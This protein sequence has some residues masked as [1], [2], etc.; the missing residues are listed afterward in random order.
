M[1]VSWLHVSSHT[2]DTALSAS[3]HD[4]A[5]PT[6]CFL[7]RVLPDWTFTLFGQKFSLNP[8]PFNH[9]EHMMISLMANVSFT[10]PYTF[11]IIPVQ[12]MPQYFNMPFARNRGYQLCISL[13]VNLFGVGMAGV[14]RRFLVYPSIAIW[15]QNLPYVALIK[16]FHS[17]TDEPVWGPGKRVYTW[18]REKIFLWGTAFM[19]VYFMLPGYM[20]SI[21]PAHT[22]CTDPRCRYLFGALSLFSWITWIAP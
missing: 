22:S 8:G 13:A 20:Q 6:G 16:A 10:A 5:D 4:L 18:S 12:A 15:P 2:N 21:S 19:T 17:K 1:S 14:L 3:T 7:A 11:Y 9:K